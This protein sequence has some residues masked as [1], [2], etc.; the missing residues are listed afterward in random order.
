MVNLATLVVIS[1][2]NFNSAYRI[3]S[4]LNSRGLPLAPADIFKSRVIGEIPQNSQKS[5]TTTWEDYEQALGRAEFG[6]LFRDIRTIYTLEKSTKNLLQ[7]F[8]EKVLNSYLEKGDGIEFMEEILIPYARAADHLIH[9]D[10]YGDE[11][12]ES[13]N[14]WMNHL[15][16]LGNEEWRPAALWALKEHEGDKEFLHQFFQKLERLAASM[17]I[18]KVYY[19]H[20]AT[21]YMRL[22][23]QLVRGEGLAAAAFELTDEEK[24][25]MIEWLDGE[26]YTDNY[27]ACKYTLMHLDMVLAGGKLLLTYDPNKVTVEHVL[28]QNP[29]SNSDWVQNFSEEQRESWTHRLGNLVI[30]NRNRNSKAQ[31]Y[32]F[33]KKSAYISSPALT[34][35]TLI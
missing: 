34:S 26:I 35:L 11:T 8:S 23:R 19:T 16:W 9:Q 30:L 27:D 4:V 29:A 14:G 1:T 13:V 25:D 22:L 24:Q 10:F 5:Y 12:W 17:R 21:R 20:R 32:D 28:P 3:F 33:E 18:R 6:K 7:E 2:P 31:N 15:T